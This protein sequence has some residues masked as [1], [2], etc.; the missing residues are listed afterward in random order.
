MK[1]QQRHGRIRLKLGQNMS[2]WENSGWVSLGL[3]SVSAGCSWILVNIAI[4]LSSILLQ[5][6]ELITK[7]CTWFFAISSGF[8][9][10]YPWN[11]A[12]DTKFTFEE[13]ICML[14]NSAFPLFA[15]NLAKMSESGGSPK[16]TICIILARIVNKMTIFIHKELHSICRHHIRMTTAFPVIVD[17]WR[18]QR[19]NDW[20][21]K[22]LSFWIQWFVTMHSGL[23][24]ISPS[25]K[26]IYILKIL[27]FLHLMLR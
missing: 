14:Y 22:F 2:S 8:F 7:N 10:H 27:V 26:N 5:T 6:G 17:F 1:R 13:I 18:Q 9:F 11:I 16:K 24:W 25:L 20:A 23:I 15:S 4:I 21:E 12:A 19:H 3:V